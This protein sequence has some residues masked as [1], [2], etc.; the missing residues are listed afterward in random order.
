MYNLSDL[1]HWAR[2]QASPTFACRTPPPPHPAYATNDNTEE[3]E[4]TIHGVIRGY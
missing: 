2:P 4:N 3:K 1:Y